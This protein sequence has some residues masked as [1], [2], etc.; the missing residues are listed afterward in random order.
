M[1]SGLSEG[2]FIEE[3]KSE[4]LKIFEANQLKYKDGFVRFLPSGQCQRK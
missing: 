2:V 3:M 1:Q 4:A